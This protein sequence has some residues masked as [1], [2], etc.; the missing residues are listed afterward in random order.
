ML[1]GISSAPEQFQKQ[2]NEILSDLPGVV[3]LIDD[4]LTYD[5]STQAEHD[6]HLQ[7]ALEHI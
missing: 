5:N 7:A 1:F 2:I 4:I 6:K 3:C